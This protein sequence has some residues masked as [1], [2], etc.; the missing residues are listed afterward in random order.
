MV[1]WAVCFFESPT[2]SGKT[3]SIFDTLLPYY[4]E[5]SKKIL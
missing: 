4:A 2:G 3:T 1:P 5:N